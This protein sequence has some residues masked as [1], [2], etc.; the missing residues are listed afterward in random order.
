MLFYV[1]VNLFNVCLSKTA[2]DS[3]LLQYVVLIDVLEEH[4]ASPR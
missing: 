1:F 3:L 4:P 2:L